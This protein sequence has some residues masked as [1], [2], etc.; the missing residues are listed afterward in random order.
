MRLFRLAG[1]ATCLLAAACVA[2]AQAQDR[3]HQVPAF[4]KGPVLTT[5]YPGRASDSA[6][7]DDLLTGGLGAAGLQGAAAPGFADP[8]T[9]TAAEL[10]RRA[11]YTN[12]RALVDP[13]ADGGFGRFYGPGVPLPGHETPADDGKVFGTE[14]LALAD[15]GFGLDNVTLL[16]QVP[17][18][19]DVTAP[20]IVTGASSGS[21]GIYGA[22]GTS[23]EWGLKRGCAVA[24]TDKGSGTGAHDLQ[25][26]RVNLVDGT[27][28]SAGVARHASIFTSRL[29]DAERAAFNAATPNRFAFK[30]AHSQRNPERNWGR[31]VLWSVELAF[32]VLNEQFG[33]RDRHGHIWRAAITPKNTLV[34]AAGVSNGGGAALAAA[35]LD[36]AGLIDGVAVSEPQIQTEVPPG[37]RIERGDASVPARG[38]PLF[39][40]TTIANLYQPCAALAPA[41]VQSP[42]SLGSDPLA[43]QRCESLAAKGLLAG[44]T[45]EEQAANAL[46]KLHAAGWEQDSDLLHASHY[47][48]ATPAIA[49]T[50]ANAYR[51]ASVAD[52]LCG[53]SFGATDSAGLPVPLAPASGAQ[54]FATANGI[55]P[56]SGIGIIN[57]DSRDGPLLDGVSIAPTTGIQDLNV[58]GAL[59]LRKLWT[60]LDAG[61]GGAPDVKALADT[62]QVRAS[63][64]QVRVKG[65]L[66]GKPAIVVHGRADTLAPVNHA[67]RAWYGANRMRDAGSLVR[68]YEVTNAQH[69]DSFLPIAGYDA[70][71]VPLHVY[72]FRALDLMYE[73]LKAGTLLPPSQ[74]VRTTPRGGASPVPALQSENVPGWAAD[75]TA[76]NRIV[77]GNRTLQIPE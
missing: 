20:C 6:S 26:D 1:P 23:G 44:A 25:N 46:G 11:I 38:L 57:N 63:V 32:Y 60:G 55:P 75:P 71:F 27:V 64:H 35:E 74:V 70:R 43:R 37:L 58:D 76:A 49:V 5:T 18:N 45:L 29:P 47:R 7:A 12:Y 42:L 61:E 19:F 51:R 65:D 10:R 54:L 24:Y 4:I 41:L 62:L 9:P 36:R 33:E 73:H 16:V 40:Y 68:Y 66:G 52:N 15:G 67:S 59:C 53:F 31:Y 77:V 39:D 28:V 3:S 8:Q 14:Y 50:Y 56:T 21:R 72:F 22:I 34:I 13:T 30:H 69:F 2:P 48:L 17:K